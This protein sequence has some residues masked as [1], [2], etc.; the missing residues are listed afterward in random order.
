MTEIEL[1]DHEVAHR[2]AGNGFAV[3]EILPPTPSARTGELVEYCYVTDKWCRGK[4]AFLARLDLLTLSMMSQ[5]KDPD[6]K[7]YPPTP[8]KLNP[9]DFENLGPLREGLADGSMKVIST[10]F[11]KQTATPAA[12][13]V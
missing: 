1:M 12:T 10:R 4:Q 3:V 2:Y 8:V 9:D 5:G 6:G 11:V 13:L 7:P